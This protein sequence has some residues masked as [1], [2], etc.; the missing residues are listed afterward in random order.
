MAIPKV[1][2]KGNKPILIALIF[3]VASLGLGVAAARVTIRCRR[4]GVSELE[5]HTLPGVVGGTQSGAMT[6][7]A[8][9]GAAQRFKVRLVYVQQTTSGS[10]RNR[11][12]HE[13][14][15]WEE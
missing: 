13:C 14:G 11:S 15:I 7:P 4:F 3:P 9:V 5:L 1:L 6:I 10:G 12:I 8:K 2:S